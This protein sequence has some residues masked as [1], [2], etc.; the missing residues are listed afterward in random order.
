M[1]EIT[2]IKPTEY[3]DS[4]LNSVTQ[5]LNAGA[6]IASTIGNFTN[7]A[8]DPESRRNPMPQQYGGYPQP[9]GSMWYGGAPQSAYPGMPPQ[10]P[11]M[12][13]YGYGAPNSIYQ[14]P[15]AGGY[16]GIT[17]PSYGKVGGYR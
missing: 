2:G 6:E 1:S 4:L 16:P 17:N 3:M 9:D 5:G 11:R 7:M 8:Y 10:D 12:I 13:A 14:T 15:Q